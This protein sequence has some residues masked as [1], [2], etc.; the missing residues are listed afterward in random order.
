MAVVRQSLTLAFKTLLIAVGRHAFSTF[1]RAFLLPVAFMLFISYAKNLFV[2]PAYYGIGEGTAVRSFRDAVLGGT[3]GRNTVVFVNNGLGSGDIDR[4][5]QQVAEPVRASG[6]DVRL[7][8]NPAELI[9]ICPGTIAG[10]S[11]C[12]AAAVFYSSPNEGPGGLWNYTIKTDIGLGFRVDVRKNNNDAEIYAVPLQHSIDFAIASLND[13]VDQAALPD[14]VR[15]YPYTDLNQEERANRIRTRYMRGIIQVLAVAFF[16]AFVG[17]VYQSV[18]FMAS[19]RELGMAQLIEAMLPRS[20]RWQP[21]AARLAAHHLAFDV[22]YSPGWLVMAVTLGLGVFAKTNIAVLI[23]FHVLAGLALSSFSLFGASFFHKAQLSGIL[24]TITC[25]LLAIVGQVVS[26]T[27]TGGV[28]IL[29]LLFPPMT[30]VFF[31]IFMARW[32]SKD[33][34][35][36]LVKSAPES[37]WGLPGIVLWLCFIIQIFLYPILAA[38]IERRLYGTASQG[39]TLS[40]RPDDAPTTVDLV[41]FSRHYGPNW[42]FRNVAPLFGKRKD[43]VIAV[44]DLT[45]SARKG[46]ILVLLGANGSGK[47][48]TLEAIAGL[49]QVTKGSI[50]LDS[51]GGLG[52]CPQKNVLWDDLTVEEHVSIFNRLKATGPRS[53]KAQIRELI[54]GCDLDRKMKARAKTLSGGQKRKLNLAMMFIGGSR[55]CAVD[56]VSSG[57]DP[58]SR[59]KIWDILLCERGTRTIILTT[60]FLDEADLLADHIAILS[61]GT[62]RAEGSAVELKH[63]LGGGYRVHLERVPEKAPSPEIDGFA[64]KGSTYTLTDSLE[65]SRLISLLE[66]DG[67]RDY[68]VSGPTIEDVFL[69]LADEVDTSQAATPTTNGSTPSGGSDRGPDDVVPQETRRS[70]STGSKAEGLQLLTGRRIGIPRQTW[71]LYRKRLTIL[72][73]NYRPYVAAFVI[74]VIAAG[75]VTIFLK[76]FK[77]L[78]CA[79]ADNVTE[80]DINS[81]S[82]LLQDKL[83]LVIGPASKFSPQSLSRFGATLPGAGDGSVDVPDLLK[84]INTVNTLDEFNSYIERRYANVTPGGFFLGDDASPPTIA[85][86]AN[87]GLFYAVLIQNA[88][89]TLLT[90]VSISTQY[91]GF[92]LAWQPSAGKTL[93]LITYFGLAMSAYPAFFALYPTYERLRNVRGLHYSNGVRSLPLWLAYALFDFSFV[94]ASSTICIIIF[95]AA[96]SEWYHVGYLYVIFFLYGLASTLLTYVISLFAKSQL[97]A[98]AFSAGGQAVMFLLYFVAYLSVQTYAPTESKDRLINVVHFSIAVIS[99]SSNLVRAL[100]IALNVLT[101]TCRNRQLISYP[102]DMLAYGGPITYLVLQ[103]FLFFGVLLWWDS[104]P[105]LSR[106]RKTSRPIDEEEKTAEESEV[107]EELRRVTSSNDGLRVLDVTKTFGSTV[108]V[109]DITFG[110][111]RGEVFA[112]LGPNGAGK[113]TTIS[114]IR[115]DIRPSNRS[116][117]IFVE[118]TS[119]LKKRAAARS[120]LGVCP[121]FDAMDQ[122][123]VIEHLRFYA[124]VRGVSDVE[125]NVREVVKAVGL[126]DFSA[127]MAAKLSGGNKRKLSLGVA[128]MGNPT[129]VLLDEPSSGMDAVAKRVMWRTLAAVVPGRSI[130]LTTHSMEE[131]DALASRA[132][133]MAK[134]M[135]AIGTSEYLRKKHGDRYYVHLST[136]T[137]PHTSSEEME[138]IRLW[139]LQHFEGAEVEDKT[140]HGQLRFSVAAHPEAAEVREGGLRGSEAPAKCGIGGLFTLLE[141][142]KRELGLEYYSVSRTTLDQVFLSIVGKHNIE[143]ENYGAPAKKKLLGLFKR[144]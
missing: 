24:T 128:L 19:E 125:H 1:F 9:D 126:Q 114:L 72:R 91:S 120:H 78:G 95:A 73:R 6:K 46:Q 56:E 79:P 26:N 27:N 142:H 141:E 66:K 38:Y 123:T 31:I 104:G 111:P 134:T 118:N 60:H 110:V 57:L 132:G 34:P 131:A 12:F 130:V 39:R 65:A 109:E 135:L 86:K 2:Q 8:R 4:V 63:K 138:R 143:E 32:E 64:L 85:Y 44:E 23:V 80:L 100:F 47:T 94:V 88:M 113:S 52:I 45:L 112:L 117:E 33:L 127:R 55:V 106:F 129:V 107:V 122:M 20:R 89:D 81:L 124:R 17:V 116:G 82:T 11:T 69:K 14:E 18:G 7:A 3:G 137:A 22:I 75:L 84:R 71:V 115:G 53:S 108:A 29:G 96:T 15:A 13:T 5:I 67:V 51:T 133:I 101:I 74:P 42:F 90:N 76:D 140:Y 83:D 68:H 119:I 70:Q 10:V 49:N 136:E 21:Q 54:A 105:V 30:Y 40:A 48:T 16:I 103:S 99:P 28:V 35:T 98:F 25:L 93:Q 87:G 62:L 97:A 37:P 144:S 41:G 102:G 43:T 59:R 58:L 36:N 92:D 139:I 121:Q 77:K 61:K 50:D